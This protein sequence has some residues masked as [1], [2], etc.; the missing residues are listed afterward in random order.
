MSIFRRIGGVAATMM[1]ATV[2][3]LTTVLDATTRIVDRM[4]G[5]IEAHLLDRTK[6]LRAHYEQKT[7]RQAKPL[8]IIEGPI[9]LAMRSGVRD[10]A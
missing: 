6:L 2:G 5:R 4:N 8:P 9:D 7:N 1:R 3:A 10:A